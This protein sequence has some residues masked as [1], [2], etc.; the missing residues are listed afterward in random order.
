M[1]PSPEAAKELL[2]AIEDGLMLFDYYAD[3]VMGQTDCEEGC[4][5]E[6]DGYCQH[7]YLSAA[8]TEGLA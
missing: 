1:K 7:G 8:R 2:E 3:E 6:V 4:V 5:V